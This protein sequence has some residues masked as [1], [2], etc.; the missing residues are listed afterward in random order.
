MPS[1][2]FGVREH[3]PALR[4]VK[5]FASSQKV[6]TDWRKLAFKACDDAVRAYWGAFVEKG[7]MCR[8]DLTNFLALEQ[9]ADKRQG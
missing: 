3:R 5:S 8:R 4:S 6:L 2:R 7:S 9:S 1:R